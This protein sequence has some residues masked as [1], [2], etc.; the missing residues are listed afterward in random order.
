VFGDD[1]DVN[2]TIILEEEEVGEYK[3]VQMEA[4]V[5]K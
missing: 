4:F 2:V 5:N 1:G 3:Y